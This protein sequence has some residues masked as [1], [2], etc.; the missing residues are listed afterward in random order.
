METQKL[1][2]VVDIETTGAFAKGNRI[3]E[4]AIIV[5]N[6]DTVTQEYQTLINPQ[7]EIPY[8]IQVLTGIDEDMVKDA[9]IFE[10]V[11]AEV[12]N[13]LKDKTFV[14]HNVSFDYSFICN[15][16]KECG[17]NLQTLRLCTVRLSR[18][19][20]K[21]LPS[22][23]LGKLCQSLGITL[24]DRHRA[25]GDAKATTILFEK[26]LRE[27]GEEVYK[28]QLKQEIQQS[29][30]PS[31]VSP[32]ELEK[33]PASTGVYFFRDKK[34]KLIYVGKAVNIKKRVNSH[35]SGHN[36]SQRRQL[37]INDIYH[38]DF[39]ETGT[40]LMALLKECIYIKQNLPLYNKALKKYEPKFGLIDYT[41]GRN[42]IRL[43]ISK[44]PPK[45]GALA[46]FSTIAEANTSLL[47]LIETFNLNHSFCVFYQDKKNDDIKKTL[48][49]PVYSAEFIEEH[50]DKV[51]QA[52]GSL[53]EDKTSFVLLDKGRNT[54]EKSYVY[55]KQNKVYALGFL[56]G[57][58][59]VIDIEDYIKQED[60]CVRVIFIC[61][62]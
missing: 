24:I 19:Y 31:H 27:E 17:Y 8:H 26:I 46:Y 40:E 50:N 34:G 43:C 16:L 28:G 2:A 52:I 45:H 33:L 25:Y 5:H 54:G 30:F 61:A 15:Q 36:I 53:E 55:F 14:A 51:E 18:K 12:F 44:L 20:F 7:Q 42:A 59:A 41:D 10:E 3:T 4:I 32:A 13:I 23:S 1:Y 60:L 21:G 47:R 35:F 49:F 62:N 22:Y 56:D 11:A 9:P 38:I 48:S 37:F 58:N 39:E 29:R 6:G 57:E